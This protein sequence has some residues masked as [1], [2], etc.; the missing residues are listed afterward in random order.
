MIV[1]RVNHE[2]MTYATVF[3]DETPM[4]DAHRRIHGAQKSRGY[5][6]QRCPRISLP[7]IPPL[8]RQSDCTRH[9]HESWDPSIDLK[10]VGLAIYG[11][12]NGPNPVVQSSSPQVLKMASDSKP[13]WEVRVSKIHGK[14]VFATQNIA[15]G[16]LILREEALVN[17]KEELD[18]IPSYERIWEVYKAL[19]SSKRS[20]WDQLHNNRSQEAVSDIV[21][22]VGEEDDPD[23]WG[24]VVAKYLT[25]MF[26]ESTGRTALFV[27]ASTINHSCSP[28]A[29]TIAVYGDLE[30]RAITAILQ[31]EE[32]FIPYTSPD[33]RRQVRQSHLQDM[34]FN[35]ACSLCQN[36]LCAGEFRRDTVNYNLDKLMALKTPLDLRTQIAI[37]TDILEIQQQEESLFF[38]ALCSYVGS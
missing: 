26:G 9:L 7:P 31:D 30:V 16:R 13:L 1:C 25:N 3:T 36:L 18:E 24:R 22:H 17:I 11:K 32:I 27:N 38:E 4:N 5:P 14:G 29:C 19:P 10:T 8:Y 28:N 34:S 20:G 33:R 35:C 23:L 21:Q 2:L 15:K 37:Y 12:R 6:S